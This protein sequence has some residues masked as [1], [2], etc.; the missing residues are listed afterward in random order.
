M[1]TTSTYG[2]HAEA[3]AAELLKLLKSPTPST[4]DRDVVLGCRRVA[5]EAL[6][7]RI[8]YLGKLGARPD[9]L[10]RRIPLHEVV[11]RPGDFLRRHL[12]K[13]ETSPA[14]LAPT[15]LLSSQWTD[16][17]ERSFAEA[18]R[19]LVLANHAL[20]QAP[21]QPWLT[22]SAAAWPLVADTAAA[23]EALALLDSRLPWIPTSESAEHDLDN[24]RVMTGHLV[25]EAGWSSQ[26]RLHDAAFSAPSLTYNSP[27]FMIERPE[28]LAAAQRRLAQLIEPRR[29]IPGV[30]KQPMEANTAFHVSTTQ[31]AVL[32]KLHTE[33]THLNPSHEHLPTIHESLTA[34][35]GLGR[36]MGKVYNVDP[37]AAPNLRALRQAQEISTGLRR[38]TI[39]N[40]E[41]P[42]LTELIAA[43]RGTL[44]SYGRAIRHEARV[45]DSVL[46]RLVHNA[47]D[48]P[49]LLPLHGHTDVVTKAT[50][51]A[52]LA[53][54]EHP[55]L[56]EPANRTALQTTLNN[57]PTRTR[58]GNPYPAKPAERS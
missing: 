21:K 24:L 19:N 51:L 34:L 46:K 1:N 57:T 26:S 6:R 14:L 56:N 3:A 45:P 36:A 17:Y 11:Q 22:S 18:A 32:T 48:E 38:F 10:Q 35:N 12:E 29:R 25:R 31:R 16:P 41:K 42:Q 52:H 7:E 5:Y 55:K 20:D 33:L 9:Y 53:P 49:Q 47:Q 43:T 28:H 27:A 4:A 44:A 13:V 54:E 8:G 30:T 15:D 58:L 23:V 37:D 39:N 50:A 40:L 2:A